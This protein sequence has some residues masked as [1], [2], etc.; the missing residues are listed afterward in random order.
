MET[1]VE[2]PYMEEEWIEAAERLKALAHP[3]RLY[4]I[5]LLKA[6]KEMNVTDIQE[7]LQIEQSIVSHHLNI[8]KNK[9][10]LTC[11]RDGKNKIYSLKDKK[12]FNILSCIQLNISTKNNE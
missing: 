1:Q 4:I 7:A 10:I 2:L 8:L 5:S 12:I 11:K 3:V 9:N 6:Y